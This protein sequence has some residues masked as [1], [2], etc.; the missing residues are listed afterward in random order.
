[1]DVKIDD[2]L[3]EIAAAAGIPEPLHEGEFTVKMFM[4]TNS[5]TEDVAR[6]ALERAERDGIIETVGKRV[7]D[8]K[9]V[10]AWRKCEAVA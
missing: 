8:G 1:M 3:R 10:K 6:A 5:L 2:L 9:R 7:V 4:A